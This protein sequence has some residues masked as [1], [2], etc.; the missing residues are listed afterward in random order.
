MSVTSPLAVR[1]RPTVEDHVTRARHLVLTWY[2]RQYRHDVPPPADGTRDGWQ[3]DHERSYGVGSYDERLDF[4]EITLNLIANN[5]VRLGPVTAILRRAKRDQWQAGIEGAR[6]DWSRPYA[7]TA[8]RIQRHL[9]AA[10]DEMATFHADMN[11]LNLPVG[12][13]YTRSE[14]R[15][16]D[17]LK[18]DPLFQLYTQGRFRRA[19]VG[20]PPRPW[21]RTAR[22]QLKRIGVSRDCCHNLLEAIGLTPYRR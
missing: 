22:R 9:D 4:L 7:T 21:V 18:D 6:L 20:R 14:R 8:A 3:I 13:R 11:P 12:D 16:R 10:A 17:A 1:R 15:V 2:E 19:R 5:A